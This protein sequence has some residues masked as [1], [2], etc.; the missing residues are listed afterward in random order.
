MLKRRC[1]IGK[2][3]QTVACVRCCCPRNCSR[4]GDRGAVIIARAFLARDISL[5]AK[6]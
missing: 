3:L 6:H 2:A 5:G 4:P 1:L